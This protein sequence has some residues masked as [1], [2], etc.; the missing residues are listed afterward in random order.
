MTDSSIKP[1][2]EA[3]GFSKRF[4]GVRALEEVSACFY[5]G[6]VVAVMGENGAGK[7]TLMK[8]LAGVLQPDEGQLLLEGKE[9]RIPDVR[10]AEGLG[11]A[12]IHQELN[13]AEN[14]DI[15]ANV[16][17]GREPRRFGPFF[18]RGEMH[19]RAGALLAELEL[20]LSPDVLVQDLSIGRRQMVEIAKALSQKARILI[21]DE[22][23]SSL[24]LH[25]TRILLH[26]VRKLRAEGMC[27]VFISHRM[28][29]VV[30]L[31]DR[32]IVLRDGRNSGAL[33]RGEI[34]QDRIVTLMVGRKLVVH[35]KVSVAEGRVRLEVEELKVTR[36]PEIP[37]SFQLRAGEVVGM[38]GLVGAGRTEVAR[39]IF[40]ID[41][42]VSGR[43]RVDGEE[44]RIRHP[45]DAVR[46]GIALVPE[47]RKAQ[48]AVLDMSIRDNVAMVG[49]DRWQRAGFVQEAAVDREAE[50]ARSSLRI[51]TP[52]TH[53]LVT[54]LSGGNQQKVVLAKWM[55]LKPGIFLLDE[56]TRG[57]DVGSKAEIYEVIDKMTKEGAAVLAIS[58][59]LEEILRISDR[60]LVMH[61]GRIAGE[62]LRGSE[63]FTEEGI[64]H[65]ATG[66][67]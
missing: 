13:L 15:A 63:L 24:S 51:R 42:P 12:F 55:P 64:M 60:V 23:T 19:R 28:A 39:A 21:M 67:E 32:V 18:D 62:V 43:I 2:I 56:P 35:D 53:Q 30:E 27:V 14:L 17:L 29:E 58:S 36:S 46:A 25:E 33:K 49:L 5:P 38:A 48:G 7:S 3:R 9:L 40:G 34:E 16:F 50:L 22:P 44:V 61:E 37:V 11:I 10:T 20:S 45:R 65:L 57:I 54:M 26:L 66:G 47:D 59:E 4:G 1:L 52:D 6:E 41:R 8:C 31:A